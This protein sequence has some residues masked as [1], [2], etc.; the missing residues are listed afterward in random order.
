MSSIFKEN[1]YHGILILSEQPL[2]DRS[3]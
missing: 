2:A 1:F 3:L